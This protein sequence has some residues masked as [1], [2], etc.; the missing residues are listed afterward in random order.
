MQGM[1]IILIFMIIP[2]SAITLQSEVEVKL[3]NVTKDLNDVLN[4]EDI[5]LTSSE[6]VCTY[7]RVPVMW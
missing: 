6:V 2:W 7:S 5:V 1:T 4:D 3:Q